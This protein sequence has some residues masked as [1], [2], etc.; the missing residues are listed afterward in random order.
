MGLTTRRDFL[1]ASAAA[2]ALLAVPELAGCGSDPSAQIA[3]VAI[4]PAIGIGRVGNSRESFYFGPEVPG[5][6]PHAPGGYKDAGGAMARQAA[7]FRGLGLGR[8]GRRAR[9]L[10]APEAAI[11]RRGDVAHMQPR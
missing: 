3:S 6:L 7:R 4:H 8:H 11:T 2:G 10:T 1:R 9:E 5:A